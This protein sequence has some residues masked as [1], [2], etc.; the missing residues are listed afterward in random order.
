MESMLRATS[1]T[2][3]NMILLR[4]SAAAV[5]WEGTVL[6][7]FW[8]TSK[9]AIATNVQPSIVELQSQGEKNLGNKIYCGFNITNLTEQ[10]LTKWN[11][12]HLNNCKSHKG[13]SWQSASTGCVNNRAV[14]SQPNP[15]PGVELNIAS[16]ENTHWNN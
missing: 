3:I 12:D 1:Y 4:V 14:D 6:A 15:R 7:A 8:N 5:E 16:P 11:K 2:I 13:L 10:N 9:T